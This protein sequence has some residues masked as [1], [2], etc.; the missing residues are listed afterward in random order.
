MS[1]DPM[2]ERPPVVVYANWITPRPQQFELVLDVGQKIFG[3]DEPTF[4]VRIF[5]S[6]EEASVLRK[7][8]NSQL[9]SF[10]EHVGPIRVGE[11]LAFPPEDF[12]PNGGL[13]GEEE[14]EEDEEDER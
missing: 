9:A 1:D 8:L 4:D 10:E 5:L 14:D 2:P 3:E 6:W 13:N 7:M 12:G 11:P